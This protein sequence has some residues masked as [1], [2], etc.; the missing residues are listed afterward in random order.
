MTQNEM[1]SQVLEEIK[2]RRNS[3]QEIEKERL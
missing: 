1:F 3:W 2:K